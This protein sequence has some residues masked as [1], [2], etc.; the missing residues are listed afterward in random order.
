MLI[1]L[2]IEVQ[3]VQWKRDS[4]NVC[5]S[6]CNSG[7]NWRVYHAQRL[8]GRNNWNKTIRV[9][10]GEWRRQTDLRS[11]FDVSAVTQQQLDDWNTTLLTGDMQRCEAILPHTRHYTSL[12]PS[13]SSSSSSSSTLHGTS[14]AYTF[15]TT[16]SNVRRVGPRP[17]ILLDG[18]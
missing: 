6:S 2:A 13:S 9:R 8:A 14:Y 16:H 1:P 18:L 3:I 5:D 15:L 17:T 10:S 11:A 7:K 4:L 12:A